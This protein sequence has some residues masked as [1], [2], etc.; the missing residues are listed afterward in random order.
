MRRPTAS[1]QPRANATEVVT[2]GSLPGVSA[3]FRSQP[4]KTRLSSSLS[5]SRHCCRMRTSRGQSGWVVGTTRHSRACVGR[6]E[7]RHINSQSEAQRKN[8][9]TLAYLPDGR[10]FVTV[11]LRGLEPLTPSLPVR[12]ATSC[13]IAPERRSTPHLVCTHI[14]PPSDAVRAGVTLRCLMPVNRYR[15]ASLRLI[16]SCVLTP[17]VTPV[18]FSTIVTPRSPPATPR[19]NLGSASARPAQ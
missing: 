2:I 17:S 3:N 16:F 5:S 18:T 7:G 1:R 15:P 9:P 6:E 8:R 10:C 12:C 13:A 4:L 11:E 14:T 19:L